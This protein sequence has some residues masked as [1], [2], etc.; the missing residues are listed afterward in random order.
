MNNNNKIKAEESS[1]NLAVFLLVAVE[2]VRLAFDGRVLAAR[3][4]RV[5]D[6]A[7][8]MIRVPDGSFG[9]RILR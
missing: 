1:I 3:E 6:P 2:T 8:E 7:A 9:A 5:A 4:G